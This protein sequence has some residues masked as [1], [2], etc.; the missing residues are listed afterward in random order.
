MA[1]SVLYSKEASY[2]TGRL[3]QH[4]LLTVELIKVSNQHCLK[5]YLK[6]I[7]MIEAATGGVLQEKA[8]LEISQNSQEITCARTSFSINLQPY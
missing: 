7:D 2:I 1:A 5:L 3:K 6:K 8:F 4:I